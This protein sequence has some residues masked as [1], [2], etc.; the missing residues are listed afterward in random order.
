MTKRVV[1]VRSV[2]LVLVLAMIL[3]LPQAMAAP[4]VGEGSPCQMNMQCGGFSPYCVFE[5]ATGGTCRS[6]IPWDAELSFEVG[7][8]GFSVAPGPLEVFCPNIG[9][10]LEGTYCGP[11][12]YSKAP[13]GEDPVSCGDI[14]VPCQ[15]VGTHGSPP[16]PS[17]VF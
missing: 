15:P 17:E 11:P 6:K 4:T 10:S 2:V 9:V 12:F 13:W 8:E 7:E 5:P 3:V 14:V 1:R 16:G